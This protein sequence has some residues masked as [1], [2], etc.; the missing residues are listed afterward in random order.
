MKALKGTQQSF[1]LLSK[2]SSQYVGL[3]N[4]GNSTIIL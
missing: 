2:D 4:L 1:Q 3:E